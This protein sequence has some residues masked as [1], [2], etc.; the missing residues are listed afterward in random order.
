MSTKNFIK[1]K[2]VKVTS[3]KQLRQKIT[4]GSTLEAIFDL[5]GSD[6]SY[7]TAG[8]LAI[9]PENSESLVVEFARLTKLDLN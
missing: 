1:S 8:N 6:L 7:T 3:I 2:H 4:D 5:S 9:Y